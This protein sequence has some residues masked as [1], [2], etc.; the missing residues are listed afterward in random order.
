[1][2]KFSKRPRK[3]KP[4]LSNTRRIYHGVS[5][6]T[7]SKCVCDAA[8]K[9][10]GRRFLLDEAPRLP[11]DECADARNCICIYKHF[12]DRRREYRV[13]WGRRNSIRAGDD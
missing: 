5:I 6:K 13:R 11:L 2:F 10:Q 3:P 1:M 12:N 7:N 8:T 9:L 4:P